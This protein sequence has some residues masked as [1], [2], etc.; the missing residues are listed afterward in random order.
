MTPLQL[1]ESISFTGPNEDREYW[2]H[3]KGGSLGSGLNLG[4]A[5]LAAPYIEKFESKRREIINRE[6]E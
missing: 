2:L 1:L 3:F 5:E 4:S 6:A